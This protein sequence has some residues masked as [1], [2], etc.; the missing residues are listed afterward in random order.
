[1]R[2]S[3]FGIEAVRVNGNL[4]VWC[5]LAHC[6]RFFY[7]RIVQNVQVNMMTARNI[8]VVFG[9]TLIRPRPEDIM[10]VHVSCMIFSTCDII[11][12]DPSARK[13]VANSGTH[14][15]MIELLLTQGYWL[16]EADD[17]IIAFDIFLAL[18][19]MIVIMYNSFIITKYLP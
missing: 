19:P 11:C 9:P 5:M 1:M 18:N 4:S 15:I 16:D 10:L 3:E 17:G 12:C 8:A 6:D 7:C 14:I 2:A 13:A